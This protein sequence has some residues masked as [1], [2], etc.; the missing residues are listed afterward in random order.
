MIVSLEGGYNI[1]WRKHVRLDCQEQ[2]IF[3][4]AARGY[5][6]H[7]QENAALMNCCSRFLSSALLEI[8]SREVNELGQLGAI[9]GGMAG[10]R[11]SQRLMA[12]KWLRCG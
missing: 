11:P 5:S 9:I 4:K 10:R 8:A 7:I 12:S 2:L 6:Y 1:S 3:G